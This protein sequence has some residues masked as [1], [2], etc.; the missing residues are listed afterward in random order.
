MER[1]IPEQAQ[2]RQTVEKKMF[3]VNETMLDLLFGANPITDDE[4]RELITKRPEV[5]GRFAKYLGKR[6][7]K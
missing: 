4:L 1:I 5:Y 6:P 3:S 2:I 7:G